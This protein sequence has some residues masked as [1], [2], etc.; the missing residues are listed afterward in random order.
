MIYFTVSN[1][2][3]IH[4]YLRFC[5]L[6]KKQEVIPFTLSDDVVHFFKRYRVKIISPKNIKI[7]SK[8]NKNN[9]NKLADYLSNKFNF[10][11]K[12]IFIDRLMSNEILFIVRKISKKVNVLN[13][14]DYEV[15]KSYRNLKLFQYNLR[16]LLR[17]VKYTLILGI[18]FK[19]FLSHDQ[20][21]IGIDTHTLKLWGVKVV[22]QFA[23]RKNY[24]FDHK[25]KWIFNH[26][27]KN[28]NYI[29]SKKKGR[30]IFALGNSINDQCTFYDVSLRKKIINLLLKE[31]R[32]RFKL[33]YSPRATKFEFVK[34]YLIDNKF[35][36]E[37]ICTDNDIIVTDYSTSL[38]TCAK[39]G[40]KT[41]S[42]LNMSKVIDK[43]MFNFWKQW[44]TKHQSKY[45][46]FPNSN[47]ELITYI[48]KANLKA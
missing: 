33:K 28:K 12:F 19:Y 46:V 32:N 16:D 39:K 15:T 23:N 42:I 8:L 20:K 5:E 4:H 13:Y 29:R 36:L 11:D 30:I 38:I 27:S 7:K 48:K 1:L 6:N 45:P 26:S 3:H 22:K 21:C 2:S 17:L 14:E 10:G 34:S 43:K 9:L 24:I 41:I 37:E 25:A 40:S 31:F 18:K 35:M 47:K 44:L